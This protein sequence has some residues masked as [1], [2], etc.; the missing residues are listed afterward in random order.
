MSLYLLD[1]APMESNNTESDQWTSS[2]PPAK[3]MS[4]LPN[5]IGSLALPMQCALVEQAEE[6]E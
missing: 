5:W 4:C 6:I 3:T 1:S 2:P